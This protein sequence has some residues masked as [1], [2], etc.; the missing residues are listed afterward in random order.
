MTLAVWGGWALS[1]LDGS[2]SL[3]VIVENEKLPLF[4]AKVFS[5][6][7]S[8]QGL[9]PIMDVFSRLF[10]LP[11]DLSISHLKNNPRGIK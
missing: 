9:L 11:L 3:A 6:P 1:V 8:F 5:I 4:S 7:P 10:F 2:T